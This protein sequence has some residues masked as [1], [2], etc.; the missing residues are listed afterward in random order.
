MR[1]GARRGSA[2]RRSLFEKITVTV[3]QRAQSTY[4]A[5]I[6]TSAFVGDKLAQQRIVD[7]V[8][9]GK[10]VPNVQNI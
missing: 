10:F 5:S 3:T 6:A 9:I 4:E 8:H 2:G 1:T 7:S